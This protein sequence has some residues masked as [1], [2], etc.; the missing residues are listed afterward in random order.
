MAHQK[1]FSLIEVLISLMLVTILGLALLEQQTQIRQLL[2]QLGLRTQASQFLDQIDESL[3]VGLP[4]LPIAP[5]PYFFE[6]NENQH[7]IIL[8]LSWSKHF[9][10]LTR[11]RNPIG[12]LQ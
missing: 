2:T 7:H 3:F 10:T 4:V 5:S 12:T 8:R 9:G 11:K 1:G 6:L